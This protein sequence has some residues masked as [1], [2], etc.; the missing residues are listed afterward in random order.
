MNITKF[1]VLIVEA[2]NEVGELLKNNI[3]AEFGCTVDLAN[4][5]F[6][7]LNLLEENQYD[8][9][10]TEQYLPAPQGVIKGNQM[11]S[12][13]RAKD[14]CNSDV[15]VLFFSVYSQE[16]FKG[17][18]S[19]CENIFVLDKTST[20]EKYLTWVKILLY[21]QHKKNGRKPLV[22]EVTQVKDHHLQVICFAK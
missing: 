19:N 12:E 10:S 9:I 22:P 8:L 1:R 15:P 2:D 3:E 11:I 6:L 14:H 7:A 16:V 13:L 17:N 20:M 4:S 21:S 18:L 5:G